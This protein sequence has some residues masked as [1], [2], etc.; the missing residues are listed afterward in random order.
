MAPEEKVMWEVSD[1]FLTRGA[2]RLVTGWPL[3]S[4]D[5]PGL[6]S[7]G[8]KFG[9]MVSCNIFLSFMDFHL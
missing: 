3:P 4:D 8:R 5:L 6:D 2:A 9:R 7:S 1:G